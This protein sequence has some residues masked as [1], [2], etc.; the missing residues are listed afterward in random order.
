MLQCSAF[1][2]CVR[3]Y[4]QQPTRKSHYSVLLKKSD[5]AIPWIVLYSLGDILT[6]D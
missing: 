5:G 4:W 2:V 1:Y 6:I 3:F